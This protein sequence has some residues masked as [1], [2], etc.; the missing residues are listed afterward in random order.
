LAGEKFQAGARVLARLG[1][2]LDTTIY[3]PQLPELADFAGA[4]PDLTIILNHIG[5]L[6]R[7]GPYGNRDDDVLPIWRKGIAAVAACPNVNIKLGGVGQ[8][9]YG[10]DWYARTN[11]IG[12]EELAES[13]A[14]LM[15]WGL[16]T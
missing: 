1:L 16:Y 9:R 3:F 12:S 8:P 15:N 7:V 4:V 5:G 14:P 13:Q 6:Y 10:F 2:S 11:P